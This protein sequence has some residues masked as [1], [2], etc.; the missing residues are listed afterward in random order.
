MG[1]TVDAEAYQQEPY[2]KRMT[3]WATTMN[4]NDAL[5]PG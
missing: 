2:S 4:E 1:M 3:L 5:E